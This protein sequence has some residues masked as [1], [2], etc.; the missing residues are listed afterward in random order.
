[1]GVVQAAAFV[2]QGHSLHVSCSIG[3]SIYPE[4]G[5]DAE[6]LIKNADAALYRAKD[7]G[8]SN[9]QFFTKAMNAQV[10]ERLTLENDLRLALNKQELFLVY[11]P[12]MDVSTERI[13]GLE[14]LLRWQHPELGLVPPD[15]FIRIAENCGLI[16]PIGEWVLRTACSQ[17]RKWQDEGLPA[18]TI[19]V[20]VSAVQFRQEGFGELVRKV[21][22]ETG[23]RH[24]S[25]KL[26]RSSCV[27]RWFILEF[28][29]A[30]SDDNSTAAV[31][32]T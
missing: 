16:L 4:H 8:R 25:A 9:F 20:N 22:R 13:T 7:S 27:R 30:A 26:P 24:S 21:L 12:Q 23:R 11:Q 17:A 19:A 31:P 10:V 3:I 29:V 6:T 14:A 1:M 5:E 32:L 2:I 18:V 15:K 28:A